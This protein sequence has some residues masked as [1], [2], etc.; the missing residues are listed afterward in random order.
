MCKRKAA[1]M[2]RITIFGAVVVRFEVDRRR[3]EVRQQPPVTRR[4]RVVMVIND[5]C[6]TNREMRSVVTEAREN[7]GM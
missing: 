1:E 6:R 4:P 7:I 2:P 3:T 5:W